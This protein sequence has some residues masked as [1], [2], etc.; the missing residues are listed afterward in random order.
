MALL[1][2]IA[3]H[4]VDLF[5]TCFGSGGIVTTWVLCSMRTGEDSG[6]VD[7][8]IQFDELPVSDDKDDTL[9]RAGR[10]DRRW[11][12]TVSSGTGIGEPDRRFVIGL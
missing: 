3:L 11:R 10:S 12:E 6:D 9:T 2:V 8:G 7:I 4:I 5:P 1:R